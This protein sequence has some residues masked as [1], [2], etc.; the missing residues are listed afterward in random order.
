MKRILFIV[1]MT[2][3]V[4]ISCK[5]SCNNSTESQDALCASQEQMEQIVRT[6]EY[7][8]E[9]FRKGDGSITAKAFAEHAHLSW[10][11][12]GALQTI[13]VQTY[14][15]RISSRP[16]DPASYKILSCN[17]LEDIATVSIELQ[18]GAGEVRH[19]YD[20]FAMV[21]V[22]NEWKIVSKIYHRRSL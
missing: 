4:L 2:S 22:G 19:F 13:T 6:L 14:C 10:V 3:I 1:A 12:D 15:D 18:V 11:A 8:A 7:Y 5:N 9:G 21:R 20:I 17:I 16:A